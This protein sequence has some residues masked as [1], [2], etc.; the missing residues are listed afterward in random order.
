MAK[1]FTKH[2]PLPYLSLG[3]C[4]LLLTGMTQR[5]EAQTLEEDILE[6]SQ[7]IFEQ[8][9][10]LYEKTD[11]IMSYSICMQ[12]EGEESIIVAAASS[13]MEIGD[14]LGYWFSPEGGIVAIQVFHTG[15]TFFFEPSI[16]EPLGIVLDDGTVQ[17]EF[18]DEE[19]NYLVNLVTDTS[20]IDEIFN[21]F[22]E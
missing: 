12:E 20:T 22:I 17:T 9:C 13:L 15:E 14:G 8:P 18:T 5:V 7:M 3:L 6:I 21:V 16:G 2:N 1:F 19:Y 11:D 10:T 4:S